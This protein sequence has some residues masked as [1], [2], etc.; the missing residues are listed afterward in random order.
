MT[1]KDL[2]T[3]EQMQ[4][5][6]VSELQRSIEVPGRVLMLLHPWHAPVVLSRAWCLVSGLN[7]LPVNT[8][9]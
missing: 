8:D 5:K 1:S 9:F 6:V 4:E 2:L 7:R 3:K